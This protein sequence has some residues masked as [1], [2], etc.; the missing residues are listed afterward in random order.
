MRHKTDQECHCYYL[1]K[2]TEVLAFSL[3]WPIKRQNLKVMLK[4]CWGGGVLSATP[5]KETPRIITG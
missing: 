3:E 4:E 2:N 1:S 5:I